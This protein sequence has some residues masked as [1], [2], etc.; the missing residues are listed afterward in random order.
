MA[1]DLTCLATRNANFRSASSC[2]VGWRLVTTFKIEIVDRSVVARLHEQ[3]SGHGTHGE[4][5]RTRVGQAA[6]RQ[7]AQILL[8]GE[9]GFG[10]V[11]RV[12][13]DHHLGE[14][15]GD[16]QRGGRV[17][18]PIEGD[19]ASEG[20]DRI[21]FQCAHVG[22]AERRTDGDA[23]GIR[24]LDDGHGRAQAGIELRG[25]L[26]RGIRVIEVVV[27][28]LLAL[29]LDQSGDAGRGCRR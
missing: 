14:D 20:A 24:V 8:P 28:Q 7:Q 10:L 15:L 18:R 17:D 22:F 29:M 25:E 16:L 2:A 19:D 11:R 27:G 6:G 26:E 4:P 12:G 21:A 23:A 1:F 9:D 13:R 5:R 3:S